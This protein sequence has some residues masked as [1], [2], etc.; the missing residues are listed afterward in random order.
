M[1]TTREIKEWKFVFDFIQ[2]KISRRLGGL[3]RPHP[4]SE[5]MIIT[6]SPRKG[7]QN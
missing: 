6:K 2:L 3:A 5:Q 7:R 1:K 4:S